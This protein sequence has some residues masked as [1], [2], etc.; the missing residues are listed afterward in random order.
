MTA[1]EPEPL[2]AVVR[3][4]F[5]LVRVRQKAWELHTALC[6]LDG[7]GPISYLGSQQ[8]EPHPI[9]TDRGPA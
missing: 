9:A 8:H 2:G 5:D 4:E 7:S 3:L 6:D 1:G